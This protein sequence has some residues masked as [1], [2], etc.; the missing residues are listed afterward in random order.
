VPVSAPVCRLRTVD[1][2][3]LDQLA[4]TPKVVELAELARCAL[5][6]Q[7]AQILV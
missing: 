6:V 1:E 2:V 4:L 7:N 3:E 5:D